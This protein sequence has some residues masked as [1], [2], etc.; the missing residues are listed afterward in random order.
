MQKIK[1]TT[2][3]ELTMIL[4]Q[5]PGSK[6]VWNGSE[7]FVDEEDREYDWWF[8]FHDLYKPL[9]AKLPAGRKVLVTA[10]P[11]EMKKYRQDFIDQFD[12]V[13]TCQR[14][15][16]H[17]HVTYTQQGMAWMI[18]H[19]GGN[20]G[21][22]P[23]DFPKYF[24]PYDKL[25]AMQIPKKDKL[26][27][28]ITSHKNHTEGQDKRHKLIEALKN[29]FGER[30]DVFGAGVKY[31]RDKWDGIAPYKYHLAIEN[32]AVPDYWTEKLSD[33]YLAF[34]FPFYFGCP[35][36]NDYFTEDSFLR[37]DVNDHQKTIE[38]IE[39][40]ISEGI[41]EKRQNAILQARD[42]VLD[43]HNTFQ[44]MVDFCKQK[45]GIETKRKPQKLLPEKPDKKVLIIKNIIRVLR[46]TPALYPIARK[47]YQSYRKTKK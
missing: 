17:P 1:I 22:D 18:G 8:V 39:K 31:V 27:S 32:S 46:K 35:N 41:Y 37:I 26:I 34:A 42:L 13:I 4:R 29:H 28:V 20:S 12:Y 5:T 43:K 30:L 11:P 7:F 38:T 3:S 44:L 9:E 21:V 33:S 47:I 2:P 45:G 19:M 14:N 10:E 36:L 40:A 15:I 6:G 24:T 25:K 23:K 16:R